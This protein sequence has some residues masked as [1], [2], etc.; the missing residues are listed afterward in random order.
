MD[1]AP[2]INFDAADEESEQR[3]ITLLRSLGY[4]V[5]RPTLPIA[6]DVVVILPGPPRGV[7]RHRSRVIVPKE[8]H[9][10][11]FATQYPDPDT[12]S[13]QAMLRYAAQDAMRGRPLFGGALRVRINALMPVPASWSGRKQAD[14][15]QGRVRPTG[16][17]DWDNIGKM[18]DAF[19]GIVWPD[20]AQVVDGRVVKAYAEKPQLEFEI[21]H[22]AGALLF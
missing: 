1:T 19:N 5:R 14:A 13:Y 3:A 22:L 12:E 17:P 8:A 6:P 16:K 4:S 21:Y 2:S 9:K 7:G 18:V 10:K 15:L 11:P 20:D